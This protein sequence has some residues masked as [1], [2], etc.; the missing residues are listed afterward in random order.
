MYKLKK[1]VICSLLMLI[2]VFA[3]NGA[4]F[5]IPVFPGAEGFGTQTVAGRGGQVIKVTNLNSSGTGSLKAAVETSG[6]RIV[7]FEVS[8]TIEVNGYLS[9]KNPYITIAGQTA[10]SPG[11][12]LKGA[13]LAVRT[14]D[15]LIQHLRVRVGDEGGVDPLNRDALSIGIE[16]PAV[17]NVVVDHCSLSW[18]IDETIEMWYS[19]QHD[20]TISNCIISE[21][22]YDSLHPK[23]PHSAGVIAGPEIS[24][25]SILDNLFANNYF[26]N[27]YIRSE[28]IVVSNNFIYNAG[29]WGGA[30]IEDLENPIEA[31]IVGNVVIPGADSGS[32]VDYALSLKTMAHAGSGSY[33]YASDNECVNRTSDPWSCVDDRNGYRSLVEVKSAPVW[34]SGYSTM[35]SSQVKEYVL[36]NAGARPSDRDSVDIRVVKGAEDGTGRRIDS[37]YD[38]GGWPNLAKNYRALTIPANSSG[39]DDGDG[40]T[41]LE[42]WLYAFSA[43]IG[44]TAGDDTQESADEQDTQA[45]QETVFSSVDSVTGD[46]LNWTPLTSSRWAVISDGGDL[47]YGIVTSDYNSLPVSRLGEYSLV[48]NKTYSNFTFQAKV[49]STE[50]LTANASADYCAVFNFQDPDNYYYVMVSSLSSNSQLF[51]VVNGTRELISDAANLFVP[52]NAYH[53]L[54]VERT[55]DSIKVFFD[56]ALALE[57]TD[58]TF[59]SGNVGIGSFNDA[60]LWDDVQI[61]EAAP[62]TPTGLRLMLE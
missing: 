5:A 45:V 17:Y 36:N 11:I 28:S 27:P 30:D 2:I 35:A 29:L 43:G 4:A 47:C 7:V 61:N 33:V 60:C 15:V 6:P 14:H 13:T 3:L 50:D 52:D 24:N 25:V 53:N 34:P 21:A 57:A 32:Y 58:S 44:D 31:S 37:Q 41:N 42:E 1:H 18:A 49:K 39:D 54:M 56:N 8:G 38:V 51:K 20:I 48:N 23:G 9:I 16:S 10:P 19:G 26:R 55:G 62:A 59:V 40:Y 12:T 46:S 22:L